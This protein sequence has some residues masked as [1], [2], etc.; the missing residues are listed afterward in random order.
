MIDYLYRAASAVILGHFFSVG[1]AM[2]QSGAAPKPKVIAEEPS[3]PEAASVPKGAKEIKDAAPA[4]EAPSPKRI[5]QEDGKFEGPPAKG[6]IETTIRV[7]IFL[8]EHN[9]G[10]GKIDGEIGEFTLKAGQIFNEV[11]GIAKD[12]W[13]YILKASRKLVTST[14]AAYRLQENDFRFVMPNLPSKPAEQAKYKYLGY[15]S[16]GEFVSE[17]Y[18]TSVECLTRIN[19]GVNFAKL[20]VGDLMAVPNVKSPF[21]IEHVPYSQKYGPDPVLSA[22]RIVVDTKERVATFYNTEGKLFASFPITPGQ[23]KYIHVGHWVVQNMVTTPE[24]RWD[25]AMLKR[26]EVSD[27]FHQLPPGPNNPVG[28]FWA[29]TNKR[30]IGLHGTNSPETIGRSESHGCVRLSNWDAI[31]LPELIRPG[32]KLEMK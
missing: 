28:I 11:H 9:F 3:A 12:N 20:K 26:G 32:A 29:G 15:R 1:G 19:P 6:D 21:L 23:K 24:F 16:I 7:Q 10:P 31:R 5:E 4:V 22:H 17:K 2:A 30:G 18:H 25:E 13:Y 27:Q 14:Y 8:D